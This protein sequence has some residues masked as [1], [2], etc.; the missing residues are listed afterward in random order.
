MQ[1]LTSTIL[2][3]SVINDDE[4]SWAVGYGSLLE[5][6]AGDHEETMRAVLQYALDGITENEATWTNSYYVAST[7]ASQIE[8]DF[9]AT[10]AFL[11]EFRDGDTTPLFETQLMGEISQFVSLINTGHFKYD[12]IETPDWWMGLWRGGLT[13]K[14]KVFLSALARSYQREDEFRALWNGR[15]IEDARVHSSRGSIGLYLVSGNPIADDDRTL[16]HMATAIQTLEY[17]MD[18]PFPTDPVVAVYWHDLEVGGYFL[19]TQFVTHNQ[20]H[21]SVIY[22]EMS[23]YFE[24]GGGDRWMDEGIAEFL[25]AYIRDVT[26]DLPLDTSRQAAL[27]ATEYWCEVGI[28]TLFESILA[29]SEPGCWYGLGELFFIEL[30]NLVGR[31]AM[32]LALR[33]VHAAQA[34]QSSSPPIDWDNLEVNTDNWYYDAIATQH[35]YDNFVCVASESKQGELVE[36]FKARVGAPTTSYSNCSRRTDSG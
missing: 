6:A 16:Q 3:D 33:R 34:Q 30:H 4:E 17:V 32:F 13:E 25:T 15:H 1:L 11:Q 35:L 10:E 21:T 14:E 31:D 27:K 12:I 2:H 5:D 22:H 24:F 18:Q 29:D 20:P 19:G 36:I 8:R 26:G 23:H 9:M 7:R 28:N